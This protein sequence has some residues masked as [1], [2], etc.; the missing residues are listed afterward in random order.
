M[1]KWKLGLAALSFGIMVTSGSAFADVYTLELNN[2]DDVMT[3]FITNSGN[4]DTQ[5]LQN[6]FGNDTGPVDIS[7]DITPGANDLTIQDFND[8]GGWTYG[9]IFQVNGITYAQGSCGNAGSFG[10]NDNA[11]FPTN[12]VAFTTDIRFDVNADGNLIASPLPSTWTML[13]AGFV[14]L[15]FFAYRGSK[16]NVAAVASA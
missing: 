9:Y 11:Q 16:K 3:A 6:T 2:T 15:G 14:G 8:L 1:M 5:I 10:C 7:S 12:A 13:I 4:S